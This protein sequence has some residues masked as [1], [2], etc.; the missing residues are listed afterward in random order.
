MKN[1]TQNEC[2]VALGAEGSGGQPGPSSEP[3]TDDDKEEKDKGFLIM[4][5]FIP[6]F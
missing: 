1:Y 6:Y 5:Y 3:D 2:K 4:K